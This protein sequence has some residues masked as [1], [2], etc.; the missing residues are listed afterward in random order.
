MSKET[1][2][3][4]KPIAVIIGALCATNTFSAV[5]EDINNPETVQVWGTQIASSASLLSDD[6]DLKQA[7]HLSDLLRDQPGVDIGGSHPLNQAITVRGVSELDLDITI[8]DVAQS[9][10]VFHHVGNLLINPDIIKA[11]DLQVG[12]N[13][14]IHGGLAGG[15]AFETKDAK[16][17]LQGDEQV[18]ARVYG[19]I[20]SNDYYNYSATVYSQVNQF[21]LLAYY[22][23]LDRNN[24]QDGAGVKQIGEEGEMSNYLVKAGW[25]INHSNRLEL[26]YDSYQDH[27][28][29]RLKSNLGIDYADHQI[30]PITYS[31][32]TVS[33]KHELSLTDTEVRS[34]LYSNEMNYNPDQTGYTV[35]RRNGTTTDG[36]SE[37]AITQNIGLKILADSDLELAGK[38]HSVRYGIEGMTQQSERLS[39]NVRQG[40]IEKTNSYAVYIEDEMELLEDFFLTPGVR[41][42]H[43]SMDTMSSDDTFS[44]TSFAL[45]GK[46]LINS[47]WTLAASAT[48]LFKGPQLSGSFLTVSVDDN[49]DL[50]AETGINYEMG[51]SY[52]QQQIAG[53]DT[54]GFSLTLFQTNIDDYID[55]ASTGKT[56]I[57]NQ[58]DVE[59]R[60]LESSINLRQGNLTGR[61]SY[62]HADSEFTRVTS[63]SSFAQGQAL[64]Q[65]AG[66]S[67]SLNVGYLMPG[68]D[69]TVNWTSML[70]L[71]LEKD[72]EA[73]TEKEGYDVHNFSVQ[74]LPAAVSGLTI[75]AGVENIFDTQ[76]ASHASFSNPAYGI[77]YEPGRNYKLSVAHVF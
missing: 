20:A 14:L 49:P 23:V 30:Y 73:D 10:N 40:V 77:D 74:W 29:Y 63:T 43:H 60:G 47:Q 75:T 7:D 12:R 52:V 34:T 1:F 26:S 6:I 22:S 15:V 4:R 62:A 66:D 33:V 54:L 25:D 56:G 48:E 3:V 32:E 58:G 18:G 76:Y 27:G 2:F 21:D 68:M 37:E 17:L 69:L 65:D 64:A 44:A 61:L 11:A 55:D 19:G 39:D 70:T 72:V 31:R 51:A 59:I 67:F 28:D 13:S 57:V 53:L 45:S 5:A 35:R 16:D 41:Y 42:D 8:D 38:A 46:Y 36:Q 9:N 71:D 50:K 24:F